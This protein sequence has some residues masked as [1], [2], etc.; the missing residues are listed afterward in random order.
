MNHLQKRIITANLEEQELSVA[1]RCLR[2]NA[3]RVLEMDLLKTTCPST[4]SLLPHIALEATGHYS[5]RIEN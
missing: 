3:I 4:R 2:T 1:I 5:F